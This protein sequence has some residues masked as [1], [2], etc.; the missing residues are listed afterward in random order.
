MDEAQ[1]LFGLKTGD[2]KAFDLLFDLL[3]AQVRLFTEQITKDE[4]E[5]EDIA[6]HSLAKFWEKGAADFESFL[7]IRKFIF[8]VARNAAFDYLKKS[9]SHQAHHRNIVYISSAAEENLVE[10]TLYKVETLQ[11][12]FD[13]IEKLPEQCRQAFKLVHIEKLP[14]K[15][16]AE[17]LNI[18][19]GTVNVHCANAMK[20]LRLVY[21]E[22]EL[23]ILLLLAGF[24]HN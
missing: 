24:C 7:Q 12:L 21:S 22:K 13:E 9:K 1:I 2:K 17:I 18:S 11:A 19:P 15:R 10:T 6:I 8:T 23:I 14:R 4:Q 3:Y 5:A 16:V 20:K